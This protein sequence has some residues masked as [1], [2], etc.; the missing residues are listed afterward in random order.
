MTANTPAGW[1]GGASVA[2]VL[3]RA[4]EIQ[5]REW[6][7]WN[8]QRCPNERGSY[9]F[10][11]SFDFL[12]LPVTAEWTEELRLCG[13]GYGDS[14]WWPLNACRWDGYNRYITNPSLEWSPLH[15]YDSAGTVWHGIDLL[16]CPFTGKAPTLEP[17]GR[18]ICAPLWHS[19]AVYISSPGVPKRR[20]TNARLMQA[21]WNTRADNGAAIQAVTAEMRRLMPNA[22][23][24]WADKID[25]AL[26]PAA[27]A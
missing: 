20:W 15:A 1:T 18:Y 17:C 13:M 26:A 7:L 5:E 16:P 9:R 11:A 10:R 27:R 12:G 24:D 4:A 14:E 8:V 25:A 23:G 6:A 22:C 3:E 21:H 2:D 19:E